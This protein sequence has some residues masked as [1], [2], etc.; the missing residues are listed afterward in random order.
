MTKEKQ[1]V[2]TDVIEEPLHVGEYHLTWPIWHLLSLAEKEEI[3]ARR[4]LSVGVFEEEI[5]LQRATE[6]SEEPQNES[7]RYVS[8]FQT[9]ESD[10]REYIEYVDDDNDNDTSSENDDNESSIDYVDPT[11]QDALSNVRPSE[12]DVE[13]GHGGAMCLLPDEIL[14]RIM[15]YIDV[16]TFGI[17]AMVSPHW[18]FFTTSEYA[19]KILCER[20][21]LNQSKRKV[22]NL[23]RWGSYRNM[24]INRPRVR[25]N[26]MY[27]LKYKHIKKIERN[28]WTEIPM[29]A[30]LE[31]I[32]Y[33]Y[34]C[35][36]ED[37]YVLYALTASPPYDMIPRFAKM[38]RS[39][40]IDKQAVVG[41]YEISKYD[42]KVWTSHRWSDIRLDLSIIAGYPHRR[43]S[44]FTELKL[45]R[46]RLSQSGDFDHSDDVVNLQVPTEKMFRFVRVWNL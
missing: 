5:N 9:M 29:G 4:G 6:L 43:V 31:Q 37:G 18:K 30:I 20:S 10:T 12:D 17:M 28:M 25:L 33:R 42:I 40:N 41:R 1:E 34:L 14:F 45:V 32:Y 38:K 16:D 21:Y 44:N 26:G 35:F 2:D 13:S 27:V 15:L 46:H 19:F 36:Q 3:A 24:F 11:Q 39:Q 7:H 23:Q 22:L 8:A